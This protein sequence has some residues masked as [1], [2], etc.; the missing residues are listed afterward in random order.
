MHA[1]QPFTFTPEFTAELLGHMAG[2]EKDVM[3]HITVPGEFVF[4]NRI[5]IGPR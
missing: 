4:T 1:P 5:F 3:G 2:M